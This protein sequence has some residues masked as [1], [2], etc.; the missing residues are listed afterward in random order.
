MKN[1]FLPA[2]FI[3]ALCPSA[4]RKLIREVLST[5]FFALVI[6]ILAGKGGDFGL[7]L[8]LIVFAITIKFF[9]LEFFY[10]SYF[11]AGDAGG[12][13]D[14]KA[15]AGQSFPLASVLYRSATADPVAVFLLS[16]YGRW[17]L[18]RAG[19]DRSAAETFL[20]ARTTKLTL[21]DLPAESG[22]NLADFAAVLWDAD[23]SLS[24][25]FLQSSLDQET[26]VVVARWCE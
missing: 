11:F 4:T 24:Q 10:N 13:G 2:I 25:W 6:V 19:I 7:G 8:F 22:K 12:A 3:D 20:K 21:A 14:A 15:S 26:L 1:N 16:P 9:L 5:V 18:S 17:M 23:A